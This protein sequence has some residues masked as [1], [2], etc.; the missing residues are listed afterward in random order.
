M[1]QMD[2]VVDCLKEIVAHLSMSP[3]YE[4]FMK[5]QNHNKTDRYFF[6]FLQ[7]RNRNNIKMESVTVHVTGMKTQMAPQKKVMDHFS[8]RV[9]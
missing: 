6:V 4:D 3:L 1:E 2:F 7:S 5:K 8:I 9:M